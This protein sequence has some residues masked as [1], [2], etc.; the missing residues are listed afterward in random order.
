MK[1]F[2]QCTY[3]DVVKLFPLDRRSKTAQTAT[4]FFKGNHWLGGKG[5]V[6]ELPP[7]GMKGYIQTL[8]MIRE[9]FVSENIIGE[10]IENQEGGLF[11]REPIWSFLSDEGTKKEKAVKETYAPLTDW[12]NE[13][14]RLSSLQEALGIILCEGIVVRHIFFPKGKVESRKGED[15]KVPPLPDLK[16][17][18]EMIYCENLRADQAGVFTDPETQAEIGVY[19]FE[20][21]T[22]IIGQ[23]EQCAEISY[24]DEEGNTVL[25]VLRKDKAPEEFGPYRLGGRL[26]VHE[27]RRKP[28]I[29]EQVQSNQRAANLANTMMQRNV[30][31]AGA[32]ERTVANAQH[33]K[34]K[35]KVADAS[36]PGGVKEVVEQGVY[37]TGGG[38]VN[39]LMGWPIYNEKGQVVSYT[40]PNVTIT[41]PVSPVYFVDTRNH[42]YGLIL[43]Q[44]QQR[45]KLLT[46]NPSVSGRSKEQSR[47]EYEGSL[48]KS[49]TPM[50][51]SGR[52]ELETVLR[53]AAE[54]CKESEKY[55]NL[56]ADFNCL[57]D[58]G[59]P[60]AETRR[61]VMDMRKPGGQT[62]EPLISDETARNWVGIDDAEAELA[63]I[64]EEAKRKKGDPPPPVNQPPVPPP[65]PPTA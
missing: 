35:K 10:V 60:D 24:L 23:K 21:E 40:N 3:D 43:G 7:R 51:A 14:E 28:L 62:N 1:T 30:N 12:W 48:K 49:K 18:L 5:F 38:A 58:A 9:G 46:D 50:D 56:R 31:L 29:T 61:V 17:G 6:G 32:R 57:I 22:E 11:G 25:R 59:V 36:A 44:C 19:L 53:L 34:A 4:E 16:A 15:G 65:T 41:D 33:P 27:A 37:V 54:L 8:N 39:F 2:D 42:Y 64:E 26:F 55:L 52:W 20:R 47:A 45:Y 13:R 63:K